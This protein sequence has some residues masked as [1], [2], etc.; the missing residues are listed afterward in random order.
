MPE[1]TKT[2]TL[3]FNEETSDLI[4]TLAEERGVSAADLI[5]KMIKTQLDEIIGDQSSQTSD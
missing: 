1:K 4:K 3:R 2:M 5:R